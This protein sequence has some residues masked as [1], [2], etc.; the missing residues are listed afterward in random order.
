MHTVVEHKRIPGYSII[1]YGGL[2]KETEGI[3]RVKKEKEVDDDDA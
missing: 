2:V 1:E 3:A